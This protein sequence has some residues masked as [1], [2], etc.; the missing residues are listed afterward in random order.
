MRAFYI[1]HTGKGLGQDKVRVT[2]FYGELPGLTVNLSFLEP[3][4]YATVYQFWPCAVCAGWR[5]FSTLWGSDN[6]EI[7]IAAKS[8][9]SETSARVAGP[10][11]LTTWQNNGVHGMALPHP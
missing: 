3:F 10:D 9:N 6:Y 2:V 1:W 4:T 11:Y 8:I 5:L 7:K